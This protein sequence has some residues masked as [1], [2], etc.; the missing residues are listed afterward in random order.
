MIFTFDD[1]PQQMTTTMSKSF[2]DKLTVL[3]VADTFSAVTNYKYNK[4]LELW[5]CLVMFML[6]RM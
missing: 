3:V 6:I 2:E 1:R 4:L 5:P